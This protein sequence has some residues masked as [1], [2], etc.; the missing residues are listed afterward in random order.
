MM[1]DS[2]LYAIAEW[3]IIDHSDRDWMPEPENWEAYM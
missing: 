3:S 2:Q 1:L